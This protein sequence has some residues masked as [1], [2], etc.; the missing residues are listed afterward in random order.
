MSPREIEAA[1]E[2][3]QLLLARRAVEPPQVLERRLVRPQHLERVLREVADPQPLAFPA[4][5]RE[6]R[7]QPRG[8]LDERRLARAVAA[9]QADARARLDRELD[10]RE[11][12]LAVVAGGGVLEDE[13]RV[14]A[15]RKLAEV[16]VERR[17]DVRRR[18]PL[19]PLERL[20]PALR[21]ARLGRLRAEAVDERLEV[22]DLALL[23]GVERLL[24]RE[25]L[26]ALRP[27]TPSSCRCSGAALGSRS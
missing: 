19:H 4:R 22:R 1:E 13:H 15:A 9:E 21:L 6:R 17:V 14:G 16:E 18:D 20:Q 12:R 26:G 7:E 23:P 8:E 25:A 24:V 10:V 3:A 2:V 27:R 5:A 11:H